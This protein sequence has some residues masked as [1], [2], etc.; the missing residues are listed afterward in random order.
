MRDLSLQFLCPEVFSLIVIVGREY[1]LPDH[2]ELLVNFQILRLF[3][4]FVHF[5]QLLLENLVHHSDLL[6]VALFEEAFLFGLDKVEIARQVWI[7]L[8]RRTPFSLHVHAEFVIIRLLNPFFP[9]L[10]LRKVVADDLGLDMT[11]LLVF[12]VFGR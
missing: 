3:D 9:Y 5:I 2:L 8:A 1:L 6:I 10:H 7:F 12:I 11:N 4:S